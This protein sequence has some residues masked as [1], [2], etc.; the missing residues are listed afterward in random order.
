MYLYMFTLKAFPGKRIDAD[1]LGDVSLDVYAQGLFHTHT[2]ATTTGRASSDPE[3]G[4][5]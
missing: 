5:A 3:F 4:D 2:N 1:A